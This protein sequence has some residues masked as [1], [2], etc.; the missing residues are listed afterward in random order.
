MGQMTQGIHRWDGIKNIIH[1]NWRKYKIRVLQLW[2]E[3]MYEILISKTGHRTAQYQKGNQMN[4][5]RSSA[6]AKFC[7]W[8]AR[9]SHVPCVQGRG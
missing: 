6:A 4:F 7:L 8:T 1:C 9:I 5:R 2:R 3:A